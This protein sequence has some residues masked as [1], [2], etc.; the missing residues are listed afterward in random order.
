MKD[1]VWSTLM[2]LGAVL[3]FGAVTYGAFAVH[4]IVGI[5]FVGFELFMLGGIIHEDL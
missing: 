4:P 2:Y 1:Y 3:F 5:G